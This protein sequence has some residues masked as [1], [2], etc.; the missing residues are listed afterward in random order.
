MDPKEMIRK[1]TSEQ[2]KL[3]DTAKAEKRDMSDEEQRQ[4]D[5]LQGEIEELKKEMEERK[6]PQEKDVVAEERKRAAEIT[7]LCRDFE[8]DAEQYIRDGYSVDQ[9]K[10]TIIEQMRVEQKPLSTKRTADVVVI[11]DEQDMFRDAA[12]DALLLRSGMKIEK[13]EAG[14]NELR[15]MSLR[16]MAIECLTRDGAGTALNRKSSDELFEMLQRAYFD[17]T[18]AFPAIMDK[19]INKAYVEGHKKVQVTFDRFTTKGS[20]KDFKPADNKYLAG[21]AGE[22]LEVPEGG[23]I[24]KDTYKDDKL[25]TR[26]LKTY[27]RQFSMTRQAFINDDVDVITKMPAK[28]AAAARRT[29]NKQ[30]YKILCDNPVIYDGTTLFSQT[31]KNVLASG[32]GITRTALQNMIL[33]LQT[34][35]D[36]FGEAIIINPAKLVL[37]VGYAM[38]VYTLLYSST[39][40][41]SDNT[42]ATNP[43]YKYREMIEV[44]EDPTINALCGDFGNVMPWFL[45]GAESDTDGIEVDYLNGREIPTIRRMEAPGQLGFVWDVILDWGISVMDYRGIVKNPGIKL[46]SPL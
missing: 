5:T 40:N 38:D 1:K 24:K 44:I 20:L 15:A 37:P 6:H 23:E 46:A 36:Q 43:L 34:H 21:P 27:G 42:Q 30:V 2:Q 25:P 10:S 45:M 14:A 22:F 33:A 29:I 26:K 35:K 18:A 9:V 19:A 8:M 32:T 4:F 12:A 7:S 13:M 16:D 11:R 28:Y 41:T 39:I 31:H 3:I 17:P